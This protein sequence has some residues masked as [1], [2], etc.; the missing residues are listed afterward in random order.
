M[1]DESE[2]SG[3]RARR[4]RRRAGRGLLLLYFILH[5]SSLI[6]S[7]KQP[8]FFQPGA[9]YYGAKGFS[10]RLKWDV[11][12]RA[13]QEGRDLAATLVVAGATNPTEI[14]KPDLAKLT[15]FARHFVVTSLPDPPR[16]PDDKEVRFRYALRPRSRSVTQVPALE[17]KF[18]S[19]AAA[20]GKNPF[21]STRAESVPI[22]VTEPPKPPP[23]P[24]PEDDRL[25]H[26]AA[27]EHVL[28]APFVPCGWAWAAAALFGPLA[29]LAWFLA[30]RRIFPDAA[31]LARLHRSRAARRATDAIRRANRAPDPP[32]AIAAALLHYLRARFPLSESAVTPSEIA[33]ALAEANVPAEVAEQTA[34]VFRDCDRARFAPPGDRGLSLAEEAEAALMRLEEIA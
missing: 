25:F 2:V 28:H 17:F 3:P 26:V 34:D 12:E 9:D 23:V 1:R 4:L 30:W 8:A 24:M 16:S 32:A 21:R 20:P 22:T 5:P 11:P 31:R 13:V 19:L 15:D 29:A 6:L 14:E 10:V 7:A 18:Q 27:G 33:A